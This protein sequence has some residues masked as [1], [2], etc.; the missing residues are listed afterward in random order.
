MISIEKLMQNLEQCRDTNITLPNMNDSPE[1]IFIQK[2][3]IDIRREELESLDIVITQ[4]NEANYTMDKE[5]EEVSASNSL[6]IAMSISDGNSNGDGRGKNKFVTPENAVPSKS[7][8][9]YTENETAPLPEIILNLFNLA[10]VDSANWYIYGVKNPESLYKSFLLLTKM[11]F[12]IKN[13]NEKKNEVATFKREMAMQYETFYKSLNYRKLRF[14]HYEMVHNLTSVD[15]YAEYDAIKYMVDYSMCNLIILDIVGEK[16]LDIKYT[17]HSL[18]GNSNG[19]VNNSSTNGYGMIIKYSNNTYLPLMNSSGTHLFNSSILNI[20]SRHFERMVLDKFK[21]TPPVENANANANA[22]ANSNGNVN[23]ND[24]DIDIT[25]L[26]NTID[27]DNLESI[28][29]GTLDLKE[30]GDI[31]NCETISVFYNNTISSKIDNSKNY[32]PII[33]AGSMSFAIEDMIEIEEQEDTQIGDSHVIQND[34]RNVEIS[35]PKDNQIVVNKV[36]QDAFA[37]LMNKIP[38]KGKAKKLSPKS[39]KVVEKTNLE[40]LLNTV[41]TNTLL[42]NTTVL[43]NTIGNNIGNTAVNSNVEGKEKSDKSDI[44]E[45]KPIGKY[46]LVELQML[47]RFHKIDTQ[48]EGSSGKKINKTKGE[49][50]EEIQEKQNRK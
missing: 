16:Y 29:D 13:K 2:T 6:S 45:L 11:D 50:Y 18:L 49:M 32:E 7:L 48:K 17:P 36:P 24:D 34:S 10:S 3:A 22:N 12:I 44:D 26:D 14:P 37:E 21:E 33:K 35:I 42:P 9:I 4:L 27:I 47:A 46:N 41:K 1:S 5:L 19:N 20:I 38:M 43:G 23:N 30:G 15:N 25:N 28:D 39:A 40:S 8:I 31:L